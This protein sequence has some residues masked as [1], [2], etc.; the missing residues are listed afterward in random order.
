MKNRYVYKNFDFQGG[1]AYDSK[2]TIAALNKL[3]SEGWLLVGPLGVSG[4][5]PGSWWHGLFVQEYK[6]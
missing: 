4:Q 2:D 6:Q 1:A 5:M 3:G